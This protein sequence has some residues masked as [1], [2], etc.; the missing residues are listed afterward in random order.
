M[1][2]IDFYIL[3]D[4][5]S[6][7]RWHFACRLAEKAWRQGLSVLIHLDN[8][9][10]V[11]AFDELLWTFKPESF[12]PHQPLQSG[13]TPQERV[14]ISSGTITANPFDSAE[15]LLINMAQTVPQ[16]FANFSRLSEIVIQQPDV[17]KNTREHYHFYRKG[18][19]S[20][21]HRNL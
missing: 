7:S 8:D 14:A 2:R 13:Q 1:T 18:G 17:L 12:L 4:D 15:T 21:E 6:D 5:A 11:K 16:A 19:Y 9:V 10:D 20:I 3:R